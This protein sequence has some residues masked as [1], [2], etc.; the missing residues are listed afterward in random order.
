MARLLIAACFIVA[1]LS[2]AD[3]AVELNR[4][5]AV[6]EAGNTEQHNEGDMLILSQ[7]KT[8][9]AIGAAVAS[10]ALKQKTAAAATLAGAKLALYSTS[11]ASGAKAMDAIG[12]GRK[13]LQ[14]G[15]LDRSDRSVIA[16]AASAE[17]IESAAASASS[18]KS[19]AKKSQAF[20]RLAGRQGARPADF[21]ALAP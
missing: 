21:G 17:L 2:V 5:A 16:Q 14:G 1:M 9:S 13:M 18:V 10:M 15:T 8:E 6:G 12:G 20:A 7:A 19:A 4:I 3:A 11:R